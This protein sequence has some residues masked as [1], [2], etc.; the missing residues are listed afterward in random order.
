MADHSKLP[1]RV[2]EIEE[3]GLLFIQADRNE[4]TQPYDIEVMG[5]DTHPALYPVEQKKADAEL[6]VQAVNERQGLLDQVVALK[7]EVQTLK[8]QIQLYADKNQNQ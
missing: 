6:I 2:K 4:P 8:D 5:D 3:H 1:W 7:Q